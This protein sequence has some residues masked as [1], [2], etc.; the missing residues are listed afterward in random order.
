MESPNIPLLGLKLPGGIKTPNIALLALRSL[1][2]MNTPNISLLTLGINIHSP[3][4]PIL[5]LCLYWRSPPL[6]PILLYWSSNLYQTYLY[7]T[8]TDTKIN[9]CECEY[10][11]RICIP[12]YLF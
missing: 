12:S 10:E 6:L 9:D 3:N 4:V 5:Y 8:Y 1:V 2:G 11:R 7:G